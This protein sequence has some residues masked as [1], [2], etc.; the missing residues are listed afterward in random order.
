[1]TSA[2]SVLGIG[3]APIAAPIGGVIASLANTSLAIGAAS[4]LCALACAHLG[5]LPNI[6]QAI[7]ASQQD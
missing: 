7:T 5:R 4:L 1:M 6:D 3:A 2:F